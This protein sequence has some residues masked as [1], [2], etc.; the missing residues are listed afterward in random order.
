MKLIEQLKNKESAQAFGLMT[1]EKQECL[2]KVGK[3][4]CLMYYAVV[5]QDAQGRIFNNISTYA[6]KP[7]YQPPEEFV[8]LE[9]QDRNGWLGVERWDDRAAFLPFDFTHLHCLSS[10]PGFAG[11][12]ESITNEWICEERVAE[13]WRQKHKPYAKF[14]LKS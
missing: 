6:I 1:A 11:F 4:N 7:D 14:Q 12:Y 3:E 9:I 8:D 10:M 5:W 13:H 2:E